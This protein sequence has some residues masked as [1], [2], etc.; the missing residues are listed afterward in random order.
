ML[1]NMRNSF[2]L[3]CLDNK[4][5]GLGSPYTN[6]IVFKREKKEIEGEIHVDPILYDRIDLFEQIEKL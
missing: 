5:G 4:A 3:I 1:F 2:Q 6:L